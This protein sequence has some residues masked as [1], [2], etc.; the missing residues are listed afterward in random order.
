[1]NRKV[2]VI[3]VVLMAVA[4]LALPMSVVFADKPIEMVLTGTFYMNDPEHEFW[5]FPA[6][7]FQVKCR[8]FASIWYGEIEG[9]GVYHSNW[10]INPKGGKWDGDVKTGAGAFPGY[11][12]LED[13]TISDDVTGFVGTGDIRI[14]PG[15]T[16]AGGSGD[17]R[18]ISGKGY[19]W[20]LNPPAMD[21]WGYYFEVQINP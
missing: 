20:P 2:L 3:A 1:M 18:S 8:D 10:L 12:D 11:F 15:L 17:L 14:Q 19:S 9:S 4:M 13:V 5:S 21:W 7:N 16:I 6:H